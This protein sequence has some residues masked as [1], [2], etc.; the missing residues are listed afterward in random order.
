MKIRLLT[1]MILISISAIAMGQDIRHKKIDREYW[2]E[3]K[4]GIRYDPQESEDGFNDE[5]WKENDKDYKRRD[6][7]GGFGKYSRERGNRSEGREINRGNDRDILKW[8][9]DERER[10]SMPSEKDP[11]GEIR[12]PS[13]LSY[14]FLI[15]I[16]AVLLFVLYKIF[17]DTKWGGKKKVKPV[18]EQ[19]QPDPIDIP[20]SELERML[21]EILAKADYRQAVR[22]WF[23]FIIRR[24][25]ELNYIHWEKK[26][27]NELYIEELAGRKEQEEFKTLVWIY[28]RIWFGKMNITSEQYHQVEPM[29]K[30]LLQKLENHQK[31]SSI[32]QNISQD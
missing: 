7:E 12:V 23:I 15:I 2:R 3:T 9:K 29:F 21:R 4:N 13:F 18:I 10:S 11:Y 28:E 19:K 17:K 8:E 14:L 25:R 32:N 1:I 5:W 24:L 22:I 16:G 30:K 31:A 6:G 20:E 27:T 26:K